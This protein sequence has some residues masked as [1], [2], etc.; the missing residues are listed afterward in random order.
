MNLSAFGKKLSKNIQTYIII[1]TL[2]AIWGTFGE[3]LPLSQKVAIL[4]R[5]ISPTCSAR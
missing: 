1:I 3:Y 4:V 2:V 5:K